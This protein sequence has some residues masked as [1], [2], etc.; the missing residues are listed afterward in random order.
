VV[1]G[2]WVG[3]GEGGTQPGDGP[4]LEPVHLRCYGK[5]PGSVDPGWERELERADRD[6]RAQE[7]EAAS[8]Q[9]ALASALTEPTREHLEELT[10]PQL[11]EV[12][13]AMG[14]SLPERTRSTEY[15]ETILGDRP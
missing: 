6:R 7:A 5:R 10:L 4:Y 8:R 9:A 13:R 12:A 1:C 15:I 3:I 11:K 14:I 2:E